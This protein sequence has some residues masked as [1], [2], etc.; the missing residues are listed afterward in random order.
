MSEKKPILT[1]QDREAMLSL[2]WRDMPDNPSAKRLSANDIKMKAWQPLSKLFDY[3]LLVT[4][5][6]LDFEAK[7]EDYIESNDRRIQDIGDSIDGIN[8]KIGNLDQLSTDAKTDLVSAVNE[9]K[10]IASEKREI[11]AQLKYEETAD[12]IYGIKLPYLEIS[13]DN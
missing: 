6:Y 1:E 10:K 9:V 7:T 8:K 4:E 11:D 12:P 3:L 2:S 5:K 13:I